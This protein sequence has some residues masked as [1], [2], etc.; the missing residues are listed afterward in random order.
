M[1]QQPLLPIAEVDEK[2]HRTVPMWR[3]ALQTIGPG[4]MVCFADTDGPCL[5]TA[6]QSGATWGYDLLSVQILLVPILFFAQELTVRLGLIHNMG[7]VA[8]LQEFVG[9]RCAR[10][11]AV[12]LLLSC[13]FGLLSEYMIIG[14]TMLFWDVPIWVTN[15]V[16][17]A[18]LLALAC[19]GSYSVAE[20]V[21]LA[22]GACQIAFFAT[23]VIASQ[24]EG[25]D[26]AAVIG[27]ESFPLERPSFVKLVTANIGAVIMPWMLAYQQS[28]ICNKGLGVDSK[29]HLY[30]ER[31]DTAVGSVLTQG[32]MA[33]VLVTV[34][35]SMKPGDSVNSVWDLLT[36]FT[37]LLGS[38]AKA[39]W[40]L[41][42]A[43]VGACMVAAIVQT[44]CAAWVVEEVM[45]TQCDGELCRAPTYS[46]N[47]RDRPAFIRSY[48]A[49]CGLA[50]VVTLVTHNSVE[51]SVLVEFVNGVL[52]PPVVFALWYLSAYTLPEEHKLHGWYKW[53][54]FVLFAICSVFCVGSMAISFQEEGT[55]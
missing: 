12:P 47:L 31:I 42:F 13:I 41:S 4:I 17:T 2:H 10:L 26:E 38:E 20:T 29:N 37:N 21:G 39:R 27:L 48:A 33:A 34:A 3:A 6:A 19:S 45:L 11:V 35:A 52:M 50:F 32:V 28:A 1:S 36:I 9:R 15:T 14:Q 40:L 5:L 25:Q 53:L 23:V 55:A 54:L 7:V 44:L 49:V 18:T 51:I 16:V 43:V 22:A 8:S 30:L 24:A 46:T